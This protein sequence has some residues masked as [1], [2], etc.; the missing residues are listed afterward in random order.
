MRSSPTTTTTT[1]SRRKEEEK[2]RSSRKMGKTCVLKCGGEEKGGKE[3]EEGGENVHVHKSRGR[4]S[5]RT[6]RRILSQ[7]VRQEEQRRI[8][9]D[10]WREIREKMQ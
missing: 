6:T 7:K 9:I 10:V 4:R 8:S 3:G 5:S 2:G 1:T